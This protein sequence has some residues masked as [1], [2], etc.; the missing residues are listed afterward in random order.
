MKISYL[1]LLLA[2]CAGTIPGISYPDTPAWDCSIVAYAVTGDEI[3][4]IQID[5]THCAAMLAGGSLL[6]SYIDAC[7]SDSNG[8]IT[9]P[10]G[11]HVVAEALRQKHLTS[12]K[13]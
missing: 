4:A 13:R 5:D 10:A 6:P 9:C 7:S 11:V 8:L 2:G 12:K 1:A 3:V